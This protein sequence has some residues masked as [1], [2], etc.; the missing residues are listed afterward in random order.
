MSS[1]ALVPADTAYPVIP[2]T[3]GTTIV[4][5]RGE[6]T[7]IDDRRLSRKQLEVAYQ[8][9]GNLLVRSVSHLANLSFKNGLQV[10]RPFPF[11]NVF[12]L[13]KQIGT[14]SS[15]VKALDSDKWIALHNKEAFS[16][17]IGHTIS[18]LPGLWIYHVKALAQNVTQPLRSQVSNLFSL[19]SPARPKQNDQAITPQVTPIPLKKRPSNEM[20]GVV[21]TPPQ[22]KLKPD[23]PPSPSAGAP[24]NVG[25]SPFTEASGS[26]P[27]FNSLAEIFPNV[28]R[29]RILRVLH[30]KNFNLQE[31]LDTLLVWLRKRTSWKLK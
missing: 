10:N 22:K 9:T 3:V 12:I 24:N 15:C 25:P 17:T 8:A 5:G 16:L 1:L 31:A 13:T 19:P 14:N 11:C 2:L 7:G 4:L 27:L 20:A 28:D 23:S 26:S 6:G 18:L 21:E 30:E 29:T